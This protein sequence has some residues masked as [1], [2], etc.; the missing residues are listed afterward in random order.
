MDIELNKNYEKQG[1]IIS[2]VVK[3]VIEKNEIE[4]SQTMFENLIIHLSLSVSRELNG[5]YICTSESQMNFLKEHEYYKIAIQI[6]HNLEK[7]FNI[8]LHEI[9]VC[10]VTMYLANIQLLDIDFNCQFD[11]FDDVIED[12]I[13]ETF[14]EIKKDMDI[15]LK[16]NKE[17]YDGITLHF[18]PALE[19]LQNDNQLVDNPL[20]DYVKAQYQKEFQCAQIFSKIVEKHYNKS[21]NEHEIAYIALHFGTAFTK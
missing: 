2:K 3:T 15:D 21:F 9:E 19:R 14:I 4:I 20:K 8:S 6:I 18:F 16:K 13:N 12:I 7:E 11:L 5:S 17:F 10:Y 1:Q